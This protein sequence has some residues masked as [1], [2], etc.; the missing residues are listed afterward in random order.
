[1]NDSKSKPTCCTLWFAGSVLD[2]VVAD[3][4]VLETLFVT[5]VAPL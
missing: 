2:T 3:W 1:M 4:L 5:C